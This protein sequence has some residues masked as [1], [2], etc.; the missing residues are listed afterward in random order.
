[1]YPKIARKDSD[2]GGTTRAPQIN[3]EKS[4]KKGDLLEKSIFGTH[5]KN[6]RTGSGRG[7]MSKIVL[8][9]TKNRKT[10]PIRR[11]T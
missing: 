6:Y 4:A 5:Q 10:I 11:G 9:T 1:M 8:R 2:E 3:L 7:G